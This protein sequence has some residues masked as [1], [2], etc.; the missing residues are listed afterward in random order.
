MEPFT[1]ACCQVQAFDIEGAE[2]NLQN[3]L[4]AL[5]DAGRAGARLV[6]LPECAYPAY[7]L[8]DPNPYGREG[9]RPFAEVTALFG[10]KARQ[11]GYW[12]A[13]GMAAPAGPGRVTNSGVVFGP[14]GEIRGQ[15]DK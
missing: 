6:G 15:Y 12:L 11:Y 10:A 2:E 4:R 13:A 3:L 8:K 14:D 9:V 5:D 7:Y 1:V